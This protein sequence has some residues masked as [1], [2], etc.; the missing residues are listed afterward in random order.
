MQNRYL[1]EGPLLSRVP[2]LARESIPPIYVTETIINGKHDEQTKRIRKKGQITSANRLQ[3]KA[4][5]THSLMQEWRSQPD[6]VQS[7]MQ[8][9]R[10]S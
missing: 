9:K 1:G 2:F 4:V 5:D 7:Q 10:S 3:A 6:C 8:Y